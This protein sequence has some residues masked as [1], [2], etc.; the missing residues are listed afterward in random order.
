MKKLSEAKV[1]FA[2]A[3][4]KL[5]DAPEEAPDPVALAQQAVDEAAMAV[6]LS[7]I[8]ALAGAEAV[9]AIKVPPSPRLI[10][11]D[12]TPEAI[13]SLLAE[14]DGRMAIH[15]T[16]GGV[17]DTIA[18]RYSSK[19]NLDVFLKAHAGD[20]ITVDRQSQAPQHVAE[21]AL[22]FAVMTQPR[23]L[24]TIAANPD[25][26]GR[27]FLARFLYARPEPKVGQRRIA[28][29]PVSPEIETAY[30]THVA[31]LAKALAGWNA[32]RVTVR[33]STE[34]HARFIEFETE[35]EHSLGGAGEFTTSTGLI[36]WGSK[37]CG[38]VARIAG[39]LHVAPLGEDGVQHLATVEVTVETVEAAISLG[40]YFRA[41]A[42]NVYAEMITDPETQDAVYL[43]GRVVACQRDG[44]VSKRDLFSSASRARFKKIDD[45]APAINRLITDGYITQL[46]NDPIGG[47]PASP[48]YEL[49]PS[50]IEGC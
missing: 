13:A 30:R 47:R 1:A 18:G 49:H 5:E 35:V 40:E 23:V 4:P 41:V 33:L 9:R 21:P 34:A 29:A 31:G 15:S 28:S 19:V 36:E 43:L 46:P 17:F 11:D 3:K 38:A 7:E 20:P 16:E 42:V 26:S 14:H 27:G 45:L 8:E 48:R 24:E 25:F 39:I 2:S 32:D 37:F 10:A 22:T 50:L 44:V 12:A 6:E